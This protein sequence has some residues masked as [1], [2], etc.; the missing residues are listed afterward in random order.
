MAEFQENFLHW[1]WKYQ[2]FDK[3]DCATVDGTPIHIVKIGFQ[4]HH[5]GPDFKEAQIRMGDVDYCGHVEIHLR[6]SDWSQHGHSQDNNYECVVLHVVWEH[7]QEIIRKDGTAIPT[8]EIKGRVLLDVVRNYQRLITSSSQIMCSNQLGEVAE[9]QKFSML[10]KA[11]I[12]RLEEKGGRI[13]TLLESNQHDWEETAYQWLFYTFGFKKNQDPMLKLAKSLPYRFLKKNAAQ[14]YLQEALI[15]GQAG[16]LAPYSGGLFD[17]I[18]PDQYVFKLVKDYNFL[19]QKYDLKPALYPSEWKFMGVR[20][21]NYPTVRLA[22]LAAVF[23][24]SPSLFG[25]IISDLR[26]M[27]QLREMFSVQ[28]SA[29]WK[30][31]F[32]FGKTSQTTGARQISQDTLER[33]AMNFVVPLWYAYGMYMDSLEWRERCFE[34]L[35]EIA[36]ENNGIITKFTNIGWIPVHGFDSQAMLGLFNAYCKPKKCLSCK[37]GQNLLRPAKV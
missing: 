13:L 20:P 4:N 33:I 35:Q 25:T 18:G 28:P 12:E 34:V 9:I 8:F 37:I 19:A 36:P 7:D 11:L 27:E 24:V 32:L 31:H 26:N 15:F 5:E 29:Y 6:S 23:A 16:L 17:H 21:P 14:P 2:Y 22:Q 3:R 30:T 1:V 10:E